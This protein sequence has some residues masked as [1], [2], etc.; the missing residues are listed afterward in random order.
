MITLKAVRPEPIYSGNP[1]LQT[2][3][4]DQEC[5]FEKGKRY[6]ITAPSGKGKST[7]LHLI[8]GLRKDYTGVIEWSGE[9]N[10]V[11][12]AD[13]WAELRQQNL[14]IVFQNLRLFPQLT[15]R[16]NLQLKLQLLP[17]KTESDLET[18]A[19]QLGIQALLD[20]PCGQLSYGQRQR[21]AIIRALCQPFD[22]LLLD[23][24]FS[25]LDQENIQKACQLI[26]TEV[27]QQE[28]GF[29]LVSLGEQYPIDFDE[30]LQL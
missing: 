13:R 4:W 19:E 7:L 8:Y 30:A 17:H 10:R 22:F 24:P 23:E 28:A 14:S 16:E 18:M 5:Q 20:T 9:D 11:F 15:A 12:P 27:R 29:L 25:H 26:D 6:L 2:Q 1:P 3:I 21:V